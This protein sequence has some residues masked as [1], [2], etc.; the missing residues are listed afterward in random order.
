MGQSNQGKWYHAP[1]AMAHSHPV[2]V[3]FGACDRHNLGDLLFPHVVTAMLGEQEPVV[4]GLRA[5]DL[6]RLG[7]QRVVAL[8]TLARDLAQHP[9]NLIH[10]GGETLSC[11]AWDAAAV[12]LPQA[13]ARTVY[14]RLAR[15]S[16]VLQRR[17]A[18]AHLGREAA[19]PYVCGRG[20][21]PHTR[22][23]IHNAVGGASL[24]LR[25][26]GFRA[27]VIAKLKEAD[28]VGVRDGLTHALLA[29]AGIAAELMPDCVVMLRELFGTH[30][31]ARGQTGECARVR[32][33]FPQGYLAAQFSADFAD[34]ASLD[35]VAKQLDGVALD[36]GVG[37]VLFRAGAAPLHD[38]PAMLARLAPRLRAPLWQFES[39]NVWELAALIASSRA[40]VGSSLHGRIIALA[41]GLPRVTVLP[42]ALEGCPNKH[43]AFARTWEDAAHRHLVPVAGLGEAL[44]DA[45]SQGNEEDCATA[46]RLANIYRAQFA[47]WQALL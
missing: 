10:V 7:G 21:F 15:S 24:T 25:T 6:R 47:R 38:D 37:I 39:I 3:L 17:W 28:F 8:D 23:L 29:E 20:C 42:P 35:T 12:L 14:T 32:E 4:A 40:F 16:G 26:P 11:E 30:I 1:S 41:W 5:A 33:A 46:V 31:A 27:E 18:A 43:D 19:A 9:V 45:L 2:T 44:R 13:T 22:R 36:S 34:D